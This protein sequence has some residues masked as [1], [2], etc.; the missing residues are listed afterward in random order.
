MVARA[1]VS[2][3]LPPTARSTHCA[4]ISIGWR[5]IKRCQRR[6]PA[7]GEDIHKLWP[8]SYEGQS[9]TACFDNALEFLVQGGYSLAQRGSDDDSRGVGGQPAHGCGAPRLL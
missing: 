1:P 9:D 3:H 2:L 8:I 7:F 6:S 4:A 5:R